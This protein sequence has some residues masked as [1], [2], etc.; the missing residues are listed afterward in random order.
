MSTELD[1]IAPRGYCAGVERAIETVERVLDE[2]GPPVYVRG[3]IVHNQYVVRSLAAKGAVFVDSEHKVPRGETLILSAHGVSPEVRRVC[4]ERELRVID[5]TCPLVSKV[6]AEVRRYAGRGHTVLLVG[7][8]DHEE[9]I[10]T[11]GEAPG[12]V[13]VVESVEDAERVEVPD[14]EAVALTTQTTL[15][16]DDT[17]AIVDVLKRRFPAL[18]GPKSSDI[19]Y[20]TQNRQDA[21]RESV[22]EGADLVLVVGSRNSSNSNRMVEVARTA[23]A[24]S[25]LI[26]DVDELDPAWLDGKR[27][28][29]LTAGASAPEVLVQEVATA[30]VIAGYARGGEEVPSAE[31]VFFHLPREVRVRR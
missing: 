20:A 12:S 15:S 22:R 21:V 9:V 17:T 8:A 25:H 29:A 7:H 6:H 2:L 5:A 31:G 24:E 3:E 28:V 14:P 23:G 11:R 4:A 19:C 27:R 1:L 26:D 30:L 13:I 10:G 16:I 18:R